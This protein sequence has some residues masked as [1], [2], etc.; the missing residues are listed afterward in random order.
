MIPLPNH[1]KMCG[2]CPFARLKKDLSY[3]CDRQGSAAYGQIVSVGLRKSKLC[4]KVAKPL[5]REI[6]L[7]DLRVIAKNYSDH[8][9]RLKRFAYI[10]QYESEYF[11]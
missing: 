4:D 6:F 5:S 7:K 11:L 1:I 8:K 10:E 3:V 9:K 2:Q